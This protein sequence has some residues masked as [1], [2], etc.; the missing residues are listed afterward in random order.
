MF[1]NLI[2]FLCFLAKNYSAFLTDTLFI[3]VLIRRGAHKNEPKKS[4]GPRR[5]KSERFNTHSQHTP[6]GFSGGASQ[7]CPL[8]NQFSTDICKNLNKI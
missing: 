7:A 1:K 5:E 3:F 8:L 4:S 2:L 6:A